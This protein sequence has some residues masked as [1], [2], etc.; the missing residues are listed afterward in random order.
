MAMRG[1]VRCAMEARAVLMNL[2]CGFTAALAAPIALASAVLWSTG[3]AHAATVAAH[4]DYPS[5]EPTYCRFLD[6]ITRHHEPNRRF[7]EQLVQGG[8]LVLSER[9]TRAL[10]WHV[11]PR[12]EWVEAWADDPLLPR[13]SKVIGLAG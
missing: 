10:E 11:T 6:L 2:D 7:G 9:A 13:R 12:N 4:A 5:R 8:F 1:D 3:A